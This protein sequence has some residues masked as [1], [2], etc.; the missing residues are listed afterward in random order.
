V[1]T[2]TVGINN[3]TNAALLAIRCLGAFI[4]EFHEK[5]KAYQLENEKQVEAKAHK[6]REIDVE[7]YLAQMK[8]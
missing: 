3:S 8:K 1:P 4:P 2:A 6:L 5:M 7:A